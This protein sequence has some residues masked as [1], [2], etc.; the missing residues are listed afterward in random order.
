MD[1]Q[2]KRSLAISTSTTRRLVVGLDAVRVSDVDH[3]PNIW[4]V[5]AHAEC[6]G[7]DDHAQVT[8]SESLLYAFAAEV[9]QPP[10]VW[11]CWIPPFG[12]RKRE[13][14]RALHR[15]RVDERATVA[16]IEA[17]AK[18]I[19]A[20]PFAICLCGFHAQVGSI[21]SSDHDNGIAQGEVGDDV[22]TNGRRGRGGEGSNRRAP[23]C[24]DGASDQPIVRSEIVSPAR[25]AVR[26]VDDEPIHFQLGETA[27]ES[28]ATETLGR[29]VEQLIFTARSRG[30]SRMLL[31]RGERR[32]DE[33]G[34]DPTI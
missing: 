4:E 26:L 19:E 17:P 29:D 18:K 5:D 23:A 6:T 10:V 2:A 3:L 27:G 33:R 22:G 30:Q 25:D 14:L 28:R 11:G 31:G 21:E 9:G 13:F 32:V 16:W 8:S 7:G 15:A 34:S 12:H 20:R 24:F 1:Q